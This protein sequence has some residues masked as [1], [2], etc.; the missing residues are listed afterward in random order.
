M[1]CTLTKPNAMHCT[2]V[3]Q[4]NTMEKLWQ[5]VTVQPPLRPERRLSCCSALLTLHLWKLDTSRIDKFPDWTTAFAR[6]DHDAASGMLT[7]WICDPCDTDTTTCHLF[8]LLLLRSTTTR[9]ILKKLWVDTWMIHGPTTLRY[10]LWPAT[11]A[12]DYRRNFRKNGN[13]SARTTSS[14]TTEKNK[15][16]M[17]E[18]VAT[19][20]IPLVYF[21]YYSSSSFDPHLMADH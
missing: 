9:N 20:F 11:S 16:N 7:H 17:R 21:C 18:I 2:L 15:P 3:T 5:S 1:Q 12:L 13:N 8:S 6:L 19:G 14:A 10:W 4:C